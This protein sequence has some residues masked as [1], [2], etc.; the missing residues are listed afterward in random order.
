MAHD[1]L[2]DQSTMPKH[3]SNRNPAL[4]VYTTKLVEVLHSL[5]ELQQHN[6]L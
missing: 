1:L 2:G 4:K 5:T 6:L 3:Y